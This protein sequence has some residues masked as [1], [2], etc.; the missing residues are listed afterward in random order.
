MP[1]MFSRATLAAAL[2]AALIAPAA[3]AQT[4][5]APLSVVGLGTSTVRDAYHPAGY[6]I[7]GNLTSAWAPAQGD[8][9]PHVTL[10]LPAG[11][12]LHA[13]ALKL[14]PPGVRVDVAVSTPSSG[15]HTIATGLVP[16]PRRS[17]AWR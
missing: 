17:R 1:S 12:R 13:L 11:A 10:S 15:F 4:S 2:T 3:W 16:A 6:L 7:D 8:M 14:S 5:E 9:A